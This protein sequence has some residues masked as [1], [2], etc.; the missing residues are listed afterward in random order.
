MLSKTG[1]S[2]WLECSEVR[3][4]RKKSELKNL[5]AQSVLGR[6]GEGEQDEKMVRI[7]GEKYSLHMV[8]FAMCVI[9]VIEVVNMENLE[10]ELNHCLVSFESKPGCGRK[11]SA[12]CVTKES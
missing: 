4:I 11:L 3:L 10:V 12:S 9:I 8:Y 7:E 5:R 6:T 2:S 1:G